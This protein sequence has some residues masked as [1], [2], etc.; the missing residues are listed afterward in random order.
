M[1]GDRCHARVSGLADNLGEPS[2]DNG[3]A[4]YDRIPERCSTAELA[5]Y[6]ATILSVMRITFQ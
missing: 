2:S 6:H 1:P 5:D 3:D 4:P